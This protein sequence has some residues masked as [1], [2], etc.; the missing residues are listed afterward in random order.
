MKSQIEFYKAN[1]KL[2][3]QGTYY[4]L[5]TLTDNNSGGWIIVDDNKENAIATIVVKKLIYNNSRPKFTFKGLD[6]NARYHVSMRKQTNV[7]DYVSF[8]A[9]GDILM[10]SG[11]DFGELVFSEKDRP[12]YGNTFASR[13]VLIK[14]VL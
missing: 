2:L 3:Q 10:R 4:R 14:K 8:E 5:D 13:M 7:D 1:R 12:S 6:P 11:V 9:Y